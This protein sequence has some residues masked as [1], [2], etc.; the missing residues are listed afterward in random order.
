MQRESWEETRALAALNVNITAVSEWRRTGRVPAD[1]DN[2]I[3]RLINPDPPASPDTIRTSILANQPTQARRD[4]ILA[5]LE[6]AKQPPGRTQANAQVIS[7]KYN[8]VTT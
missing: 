2:T 6:E 1:W 3:S 4:R 7:Y 5:E 8:N